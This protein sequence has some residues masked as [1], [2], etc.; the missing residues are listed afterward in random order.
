MGSVSFDA[1]LGKDDTV[2]RQCFQCAADGRHRHP[3]LPACPIEARKGSGAVPSPQVEIKAECERAVLQLVAKESTG[4]EGIAAVKPD[5]TMVGVFVVHHRN[6][7]RGEY[8]R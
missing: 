3:Q 1:K 5:I 2:G 4:Y 7:I 8:P 6:E